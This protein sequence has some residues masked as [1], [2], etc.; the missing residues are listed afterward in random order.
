[1]GDFRTRSDPCV[2]IDPWP[3]S[4]EPL[5]MKL[6]AKLLTGFGSLWLVFL[7]AT[8]LAM[9]A[10]QQHGESL[11]AAFQSTFDSVVSCDQMKT[12]LDEIN[13]MTLSA[14]WTGGLPPPGVLENAWNDFGSGKSVELQN[15]TLPGEAQLTTKIFD[16]AA[17]YKDAIS[18]F[19]AVDE[20]KRA[21]IYQNDLLPRYLAAR[22][23]AQDV[24]QLNK[25]YLVT[26]ESR[27]REHVDQVRSVQLIF[28]TAGAALAAIC[29]LVLAKTILGPLRVLTESAKQI[30][31]GN[32]DLAVP[33]QAR[34]ELGELARAFN[35]MAAKLREY[36]Q[37]DHARL[38]R[39]QQ[40]TQMAID[41]LP[42]AVAIFNPAGNVEISNQQARVH[43]GLEPGRHQTDAH[44]EWLSHLFTD[45][46]E[47]GCGVDPVGYQSA[48]Q[49][50]DH[51]EERFLLPRAVPMFGE[52]RQVIGVVII[53]VDV[54]RLHHADE[55]KSGL[56]ATVSHEL[57]TPLAATRFSVHLLAQETFSPLDDHQ[58]RLIRAACEGADRLNRIIE[59][60]LQFQRIEEG[61]Y[62]IQRV[63]LAPHSL[64][65]QVVD[66][67]RPDFVSSGLELV[68][69][70]S[71][72][73]PRVLAEPDLIGYVLSN[74]LSNTLKFVPAGG[75]V[76]LLV[77]SLPDGMHFIVADNGPGISDEHFPKL[78][79]R[80][81]RA[82]APRNVPGAGLGLAIAKQLVEA[83]GG[84]IFAVRNVTGGMQFT[85]VLAPLVVYDI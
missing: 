7:I 84:R 73:L 55:L 12:S 35:A 57:K 32:L 44:L 79:G 74:L 10:L 65:S 59:N 8:V 47:T 24:I 22:S 30:E 11:E 5:P 83:H 60:L 53:L 49:L 9:Y 2:G 21:E 58:R 54:T 40:T 56:V 72:D 13:R 18:N 67:L 85:F 27:M 62:Q 48:V 69:D 76:E 64:V 68:T 42:D 71:N 29:V 23:A 33:V 16:L 34:D 78:F 14:V 20:K 37:L 50:F 19:T 31:S 39:T 46:L 28:V 77:K 70:V 43:F 3:R 63:P 4:G 6:Y 45:S 61:Q 36:R 26:L 80:F 51:G 1:M 66:M 15:I 81:Y 25:R 41:S 17:G 82:G 52:G 75:K 38:L